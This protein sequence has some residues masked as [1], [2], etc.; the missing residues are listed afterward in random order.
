MND[1]I[2]RQ[3]ARDVVAGM[4]SYFCK[5]IDMIPSAQQWIPCQEQL[6]D[7]DGFYIITIQNKD[8]NSN[9]TGHTFFAHYSIGTNWSFDFFSEFINCF[10]EVTAWMPLPDSYEEKE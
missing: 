6:P 5:Y 2:S 10:Y 7:K 4:D 1:L 8:A 9:D 3:A